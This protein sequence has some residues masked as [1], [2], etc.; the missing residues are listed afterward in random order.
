MHPQ[1]S[2][3]WSGKTLALTNLFSI[4]DFVQAE[5]NRKREL[6]EPV[7]SIMSKKQND[8]VSLFQQKLLQIL[9]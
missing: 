6:L 2:F 4:L 7:L 8:E 5:V 3:F 1:S 9:L